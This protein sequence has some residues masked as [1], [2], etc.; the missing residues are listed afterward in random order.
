METVSHITFLQKSIPICY[1]LFTFLNLHYELGRFGTARSLQQS[2]GNLLCTLA[3]FGRHTHERLKTFG[4][5]VIHANFV[6]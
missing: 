4:G 3:G 6:V 5:L 2:V 1:F